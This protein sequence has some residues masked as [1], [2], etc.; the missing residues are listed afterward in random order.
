GKYE[1][2]EARKELR[3]QHVLREMTTRRT[4]LRNFE[5]ALTAPGLSLIAEIKKASPSG[6]LLRA[7]FVPRDIAR[8]YSENGASAL[9]VLTDEKYFQG[10]LEFLAEA[11][12]ACKLPILRKD[13]IV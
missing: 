8:I 6:G 10:S 5:A 3:P 4:E 13:F 11:R 9:S 12:A 2:V 1:E 7:N